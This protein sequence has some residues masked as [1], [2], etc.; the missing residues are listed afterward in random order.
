MN[1]VEADL[2]FLPGGRCVVFH[3]R[4]TYFLTRKG[5]ALGVLRRRVYA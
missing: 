3:H 2:Y 4:D 1:E 5:Q